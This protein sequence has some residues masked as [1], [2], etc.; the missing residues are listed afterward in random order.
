MVDATA[1]N[2]RTTRRRFLHR[3]AATVGGVAAGSILVACGGS[4]PTVTPVA[5]A[6]TSPP[7]GSSATGVTTSS[8]SAGAAPTAV[9]ATPAGAR[10]TG[11]I[12]VNYWGVEPPHLIPSFSSF[13]SVNIP[14]MPLFS[15]L[16]RPDPNLDPMPDLAESWTSTPDG[17]QF[18]FKLRRGVKWHD[19][20]LFSAK[21][22]KFTWEV[23]AHPDNKTAA[24][25]YSFFS[26]LE[27]AP[28][29]HTGKATEITGIKV[30]DDYTVEARLTTPYAPF[31]TIGSN[32]FIIPQHVLKDVPVA[33]MLKHAYARAPIGTGPFIF[34]SWKANDSVTGKAFDDYF[35]GR[36]SLDKVVLL[37]S[38]LD[39]NAIITGLKA[40]EINSANLTLDS[41]DALQGD[42][43][44]RTITKR[45]RN[46]QYIEFN[47]RKPFF[48]DLRV[49]K[50]LSYAL[51]RKAIADAIW[52]GRADIYNSVFPYD[53]WP[54]KKDTTLFDNDP[55]QAKQLLDAAGWIVGAD[56]IR[57][58]NG[59]KFSFTM[60]SIN[61]DWP[62]VVQQQWKQVGVDMKHVY[63]D[64]GTLST[65]YYTTHLFDA[66]GLTIPYTNYTDPAYALPGYF[67]SANNRNGYNN[68]RSDELIMQAAATN[69]QEQRK[70][71]YYEWQEVIAQDV[72]HLWVGNPH[73]AYVFS[74]DLIAPDRVSQIFTWRDVQDWYYVAR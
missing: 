50:A 31:L 73:Q 46:N 26:A 8:A 58:K 69:D 36:P 64:F 48:E 53:Y 16:T 13:S 33:D 47:L 15:G 54:T 12:A 59:Q 38:G 29:Y 74:A 45:G 17:K 22:V 9:P 66:V 25:L 44:L 4:V 18:T 5:P 40:R 23:I 1:L 71:L 7:A 20:Q 55:G 42:P 70:K 27:G 67:L 35:G 14:T 62:L 21:D 72:P 3:A 43:T 65:Q 6:T 60:Y 61:K 37:T 41:Y 51:N 11:G 24:Q 39:D 57:E 28:E 32:Q 56:G 2:Q 52:K 49:R 10:R 34:E 30:I 68:P 63:V 19:R